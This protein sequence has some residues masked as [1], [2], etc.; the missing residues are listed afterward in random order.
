MSNKILML[1]ISSL[2]NIA[3]LITMVFCSLLFLACICPSN[4]QLSDPEKVG[5][6]PNK[7]TAI[8][9]AEAIW[10]PI[11]GEEI[12]NHKPFKAEL[13]DNKIWRVTGTVYTKLGGSPIAEIQKSDC[14]VIRIY[15]E[16]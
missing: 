14:K 5:Y 12:Y 15:H 16:K 13:I 4:N 3:V 2:G 11:Y 8:K 7:E 1:K 6:V 9:I 10:L